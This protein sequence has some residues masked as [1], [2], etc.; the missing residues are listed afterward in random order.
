[1]VGGR[2]RVIT[3]GEVMQKR[4]ERQAERL[5]RKRNGAPPRR[6]YMLWVAYFD[7]SL[8]GGWHAF[9]ENHR[10]RNGRIWI[11]R[12]RP[13]MKAT[14]MEAF[15]LTEVSGEREGWH[16]WKLAFAEKYARRVHDGKPQGVVYVWWDGHGNPEVA[17]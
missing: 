12:D 1:V 11:D 2:R 17:R 6:A 5:R 9:L 16:A 10:G 13:Q 14:L 4:R 8:M 3:W 15:P 7:Q